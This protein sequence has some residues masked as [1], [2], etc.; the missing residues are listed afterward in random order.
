MWC[1]YGYCETKV[2]VLGATH[3]FVSNAIQEGLQDLDC[4]C[5]GWDL[6]TVFFKDSHG[7]GEGLLELSIVDLVDQL[8]GQL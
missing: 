2:Q 6:R 5:G 8:R 7:K 1:Q 3:T 4:M